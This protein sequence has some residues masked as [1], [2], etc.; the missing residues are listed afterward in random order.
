MTT[1]ATL[2]LIKDGF[3][4]VELMQDTSS[5]PTGGNGYSNIDNEY[6]IYLFQLDMYQDLHTF[7][8]YFRNRLSYSESK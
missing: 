8:T 7:P 1:L 5:H 3:P 6:R 2:Y 4:V